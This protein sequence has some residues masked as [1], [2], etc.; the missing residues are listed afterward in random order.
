[1]KKPQP[2]GYGWLIDVEGKLVEAATDTEAL[3]LLDE[4]EDE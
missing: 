4:D 3:E 2:T 1:M